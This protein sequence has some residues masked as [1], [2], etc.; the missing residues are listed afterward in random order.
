MYSRP[1]EPGTRFG[2]G[3]TGVCRDRRCTRKVPS[4]RNHER[5]VRNP[6][7]SAEEA[8]AHLHLPRYV[9]ERPA[10]ERESHPQRTL[11]L[12]PRP[13]RESTGEMDCHRASGQGIGY[14]AGTHLAQ[15]R[16]SPTGVRDAG[17]DGLGAIASLD[18][19]TVGRHAIRCLREGLRPLLVCRATGVCAVGGCGGVVFTTDYTD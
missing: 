17:W 19:A 1:P 16:G 2:P 18:G 13:H 5:R 10:Q 11:H 12:R 15:P 7:K 4:R 3:G 6:E 9:Q 8:V 14:R